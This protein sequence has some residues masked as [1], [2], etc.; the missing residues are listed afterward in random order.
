MARYY[1]EITCQVRG[2]SGQDIYDELADAVADLAN[3][4]DPDLGVDLERNTFDFC[5]SVDATDEVEALRV[6]IS[7]VRAAIHV[8]GGATPG[9]EEHFARIQQLVRRTELA[10]A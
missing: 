7:A 8:T 9:W 5:M 4:I 3:V 2:I 1:L 10:L 6:G